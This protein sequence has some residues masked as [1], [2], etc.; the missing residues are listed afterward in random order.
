M[1]A[2]TNF[3]AVPHKQTSFFSWPNNCC[4][5]ENK[6][7]FNTITSVGFSVTQDR[8]SGS[9]KQTE[10]SMP[11]ALDCATRFIYYSMKTN[12]ISLDMYRALN[13]HTTLHQN[14]FKSIITKNMNSRWDL[15]SGFIWVGS[16]NEIFKM[17][18]KIGSWRDRSHPCAIPRYSLYT[19][20][21]NLHMWFHS[22]HNEC[23]LPTTWWLRKAEQL[24]L[25]TT[26]LSPQY[27][28]SH[29]M[30]NGRGTSLGA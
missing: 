18:P 26:L 10:G 6:P 7:H 28:A 27:M 22:E 21:D 25:L 29:Y 4:N 24:S 5:Q 1:H 23:D 3:T 14:L 15:E 19:A 8:M 16:H 12:S 17:D 11:W 20:P 2:W 13:F 30:S 9:E